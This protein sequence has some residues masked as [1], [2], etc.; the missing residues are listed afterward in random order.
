MQLAELAAQTG[1]I[2]GTSDW[3]VIDQP[4]IDAFADCT[5]D[6]QFIHVDP[7]RAAAVTGTGGTIAHGF[8]SLSLLGGMSIDMLAAVEMTVGMNYGFDKVRFLAPV[9]CGARVRGVFRLAEAVEKRAGQWLLR[10]DASL[11]IEGAAKPAFVAEWLVL[12]TV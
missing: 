9:P 6:H 10:F 12:C 4:R 11:E 5:G 2:V 1:E 7:E 3:V 8:L